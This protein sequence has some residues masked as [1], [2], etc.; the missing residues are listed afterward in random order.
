MDTH[1]PPMSVTAHRYI[2]VGGCRTF[3]RETR[4][5]EAPVIL[6]PHG[7]PCSSFA[8]RNLLPKL[9][10]SARLIAPDFPGSGYSDTPA[11]FPYYFDGYADFLTKFAD[12]MGLTR[13]FLYLHD[14]GSQISL[15]H[16]IRQPD[17]IAGLIIQN[18][19]IYEDTLGPQYAPLKKYW[20]DPTAEAKMRLGEAI[21]EDGFREEFLNGYQGNAADMIPPDLWKLHWGMTDRVRRDIYLELIAGLRDNR[22]WFPRYQKYLRDQ[23]PPALIVWGPRDGYMP[24][25]AALA[26]RRDLPDAE[27]HLFEDGGHWLLESHLDEVADLVADFI[28]QPAGN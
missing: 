21:T 1:S 17:R 12:R 6:L 13:Y 19:D 2:D 28:A 15:R 16:A 24:A 10:S 14:F 25:Q 8:Y 20:D 23:Q 26:Y 7:Y 9:A 4:R 18:G 3:Y 5:V 11:D 22:E 27:V